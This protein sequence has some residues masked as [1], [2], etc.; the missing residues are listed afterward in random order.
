MRLAIVSRH[1]ENLPRVSD[2]HIDDD[3]ADGGAARRLAEA[4][5]NARRTGA[6]ADDPFEF[7]AHGFDFAWRA[8][9][10]DDHSRGAGAEDHDARQFIPRRRD[11]ACPHD[12]ES[13]CDDARQRSR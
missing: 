3:R 5:D 9:A 12:D 2:L 11:D 6:E 1:E 7:A 8:G 13:Q 4:D 10:E